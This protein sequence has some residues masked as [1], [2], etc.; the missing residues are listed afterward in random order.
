MQLKSKYQTTKFEGLFRISKINVYQHNYSKPP[1]PAEQ[2]N[3]LL[4]HSSSTHQSTISRAISSASPTN[5]FALNPGAPSW[6]SAAMTTPAQAD[7]P[8]PNPQPIPKA[9]QDIPRNRHGQRIDPVVQYDPQEIKRIKRMKLCNVHHLR[10]DCPYDPCTHDHHYKPNNNELATLRYVSRMTPCKFSSE[11]DDLKC[12]YGHRCPN[13]SEGK[14]DC[15]WG[16]N[17]R[18]ER[19][20]HGIDRSIIKTTKVGKK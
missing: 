16:E 3:N 20:L 11:C 8:P 17:C 7:S 2:S 6:A 13:D 10:N 18:F 4:L 9:A 19:E 5:G 15:R 1:E 12:I 14:S